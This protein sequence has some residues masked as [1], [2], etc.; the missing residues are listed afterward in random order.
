MP[1]A[2][3]KMTI[4]GPGSGTDPSIRATWVRADWFRWSGEPAG[5]DPRPGRHGTQSATAARGL[6]HRFTTPD[7]QTA[8]STNGPLGDR[9]L[10]DRADRGPLGFG[11]IAGESAWIGQVLLFVFLVLAVVS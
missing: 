8:G 2:A 4:R 11:G 5:F 1:G 7:T 10:R 6:G 3:G 9:V